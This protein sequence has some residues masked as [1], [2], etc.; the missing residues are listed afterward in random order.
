MMFLVPHVRSI[1]DVNSLSLLG[2]A[3]RAVAVVI[4]CVRVEMPL[5]PVLTLLT[6]D[7]AAP[8]AVR[9]L[10]VLFLT[11]SRYLSG[12]ATQLVEC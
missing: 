10:P 6:V 5:H 11:A 3:T 9:V 4:S 7:G 8:G 1:I 2:F 12:I